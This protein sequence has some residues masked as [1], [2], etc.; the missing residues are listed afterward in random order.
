VEPLLTPAA[1]ALPRADEKAAAG[2]HVLNVQFDRDRLHDKHAAAAANKDL[3][4]EAVR[5]DHD[6]VVVAR[7]L[8]DAEVADEEAEVERMVPLVRAEAFRGRESPD[9][10]Y[11]GGA[12]A[13]VYV[14]DGLSRRT[15][16]P[17][18]DLLTWARRL[19]WHTIGREHVRRVICDPVDVGART[20][21][22]PFNH[23]DTD[24][25]V[26]IAIESLPKVFMTAMVWWF[27]A[28]GLGFLTYM[29]VWVGWLPAWLGYG[30]SCM[31]AALIFGTFFSV[32]E[33]YKNGDVL[34]HFSATRDI[35]V[36]EEDDATQRHPNMRDIDI[37]HQ[38][39]YAEYDLQMV[40]PRSV[41]S[42]L[43][44]HFVKFMTPWHMFWYYDRFFEMRHMAYHGLRMD[45]VLYGHLLSELQYYGKTDYKSTLEFCRV[46]ARRIGT[47]NM[48]DY[49]LVGQRDVADVVRNTIR[50]AA[51]YHCRMPPLDP[52]PEALNLY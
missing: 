11:R 31:L 24:Q 23:E 33:R 2:G 38:P 49:V 9:F 30:L 17:R 51:A 4:A 8:A 3:V 47:I 18:D 39:F 15:D 48:P 7:Q 25:V 21:F 44:H 40:A 6:R 14:A 35:G 45:K 41:A 19:L 36:E 1:V 37:T 34:M 46:A 12:F 42:F 20:S 16:G 5:D 43:N 10:V 28:M 29:S 50:R 26:S 52:S 27:I 32:N 22:K 13:Q